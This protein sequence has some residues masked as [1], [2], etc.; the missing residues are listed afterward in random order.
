[1][2]KWK[3]CCPISLLFNLHYEKPRMACHACMEKTVVCIQID[4][5]HA[6]MVGMESQIQEMPLIGDCKVN[7]S[8]GIM[9]GEL[10]EVMHS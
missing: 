9:V 1:M 4:A 5:W 3:Q 10:C 6:R 7:F 2:L 8:D